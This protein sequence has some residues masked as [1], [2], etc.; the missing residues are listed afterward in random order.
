MGGK[1]GWASVVSHSRK[2][3]C[4]SN[5][6]NSFSRVDTQGMTRWRF[7]RHSQ[8]PVCAQSR[9]SCRATS[10]CPCPM[11][12]WWYWSSPTVSSASSCSSWDGS[13]PGDMISR[14]GSVGTVS[15]EYSFLML[16]VEGESSLRLSAYVANWLMALCKRSGCSACMT[17]S[18]WKGVI[19]LATEGGK[20]LS[21]CE[22]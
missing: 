10:A 17:S 14:M 2:L 20:S 4:G 8:W 12:T 13:V 11:A 22:L 16:S 6:F 9:S 21:Y 18:C 15:V 19:F 1:R 5:E 3:G 7:F